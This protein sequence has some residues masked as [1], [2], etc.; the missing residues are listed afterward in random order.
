MNGPPA[1][2]F[3]PA[4]ATLQRNLEE[5]KVSR[6]D[7]KYLRSAVKFYKDE[8]QRQ[9]AIMELIDEAIGE[10]GFAL[11][12]SNWADGIGYWWCDLFLIQVLEPKNTGPLGGCP[13]LLLSIIAKNFASKRIRQYQQFGSFQTLLSVSQS[14]TCPSFQ[15]ASEA[16][17]PAV[18]VASPTDF[19]PEEHNHR[20]VHD[21]L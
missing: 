11:G 14:N 17:L 6:S 20:N 8:V 13:S 5:V 7:V 12:R 2:I 15:T 9:K 16:C 3:N 18:S 10:C 21:S 1:A 4:L 19:G